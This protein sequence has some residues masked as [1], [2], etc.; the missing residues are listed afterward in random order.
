MRYRIRVNALNLGWMD[1]PGEHAIQKE[2]HNA[3][4]DWLTDAEAN[5]PFGRLIKTDEAARAIAFLASDESGLMT[6]AV[7]DYDQSVIGAGFVPQ[8]AVGEQGTI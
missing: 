2:E 6:G 7:I 1:T 8:P 5:Q 3:D 4:D